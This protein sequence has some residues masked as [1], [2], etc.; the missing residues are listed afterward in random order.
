M[1]FAV[2]ET[3]H[4]RKV[5]KFDLETVLDEI[6]YI[7]KHGKNH[8]GLLFVADANFGILPRD[9]HIATHLADCIKEFGFPKRVVNFYAKNAKESVIEIAEILKKV[10]PMGMARQSLN[11]DVL[12]LVK[13]KNIRSEV[14]D[15]LHEDC[16]KRGLRTSCDLIYGLPGESYESFV[17]GVSR[18]V[19]GRDTLVA[20]YPHILIA[21]AE[22]ATEA[23]R[24]KY[25][26]ESA[27]RVQMRAIGTYEGVSALEYE[28]FV[29][30]TK[31]FP[32]AD[33]FRMRLFHFLFVVL[34]DDI[35]REFRHSLAGY[36][37]DHAAFAD[38][39]VDDEQNWRGEWGRLLSDFRQASK[40]Q[41]LDEGELK[42][43]FTKEDIDEVQ[44]HQIALNAKFMAR[45]VSRHGVLRGFE[46]YVR[47][48]LVRMIDGTLAAEDIAD[49]NR[50]LDLSLE[51]I[52]DYSA[53]ESE[54]M[55]DHEYDINSCCPLRRINR[56]ALLN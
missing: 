56:F 1:P 14:Y 19:R 25:G 47:D 17:Q 8:G 7:S 16:E 40:D 36:N 24:Q 41:L 10:A 28:E 30:G 50:A 29:I 27:Y 12:E 42:I 37:L 32:V 26:I 53:Y 38:F 46:D 20:I 48:A 39:I 15:S 45:L 4:S 54:K 43:E 33:F 13:R 5:K 51:S 18:I 23:Y 21:G 22:T 55:V 11:E 49:L 35:F 3:R 9:L 6:T 2:G 31:D 34:G 52:I 44:T